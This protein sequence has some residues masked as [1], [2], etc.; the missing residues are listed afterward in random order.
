MMH[1]IYFPLKRGV[2][3]RKVL[4]ANGKFNVDNPEWGWSC[5]ISPL[6]VLVGLVDGK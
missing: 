3:G 4:G 5:V 6:A 2:S 1:P